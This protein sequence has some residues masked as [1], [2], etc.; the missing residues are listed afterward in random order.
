M[1]KQDKAAATTTVTS[2]DFISESQWSGMLELQPTIQRHDRFYLDEM[3]VRS[4]QVLVQLNHQTLE[5]RRE[6]ALHFSR[7]THL[8]VLQ[9]A[10]TAVYWHKTSK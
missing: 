1:Y 4:V 3:V 9:P 10:H 2:T 8:G 7:I 6:L 5:E